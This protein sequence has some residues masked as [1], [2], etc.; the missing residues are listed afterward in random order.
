MDGPF[1]LVHRCLHDG[2]PVVLATVIEL[3]PQPDSAGSLPRLG[4]ELA[5]EPNSDP[6]GALGGS[7]LMRVVVRD[8]Q[9]ALGTGR[10]V[11]RHY[12]PRGEAGQADVTVFIHVFASPH[13]MLIFGA[14][15]FTAALVRIAKV[16]GYHVTVCDARPVFAT[17]QRFPEADE[18]IAEWPHR[19]LEKV[20]DELG[21]TDAICVLTHDHKFDI[22]VLVAALHTDV[23]YLGAMGSRSTHERRVNLLR[24]EGVEAERIRRIMAPIGIDI[25]ARTPEETAVSICAEIIAIRSGAPAYSLRDSSGPIHRLVP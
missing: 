3:D 4:A 8:M 22:P 21:P 13:R 5:M 9:G 10:S 23:G 6:V 11:T 12:G 2:V 16:L 20:A 14:V 15:D 24:A 7:E 25:G 18:V 17:A 19:Y 1:A